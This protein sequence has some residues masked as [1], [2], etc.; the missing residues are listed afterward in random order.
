[1]LDES[2]LNLQITIFLFVGTFIF[3]GVSIKRKDLIIYL[4]AY[5]LAP[6]GYLFTYRF[7]I[8]HIDY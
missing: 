3:I 2:I 4:P 7:L 1:M 8:T 5:I 6:I